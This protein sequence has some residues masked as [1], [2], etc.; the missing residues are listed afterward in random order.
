MDKWKQVQ[1]VHSAY[2]DTIKDFLFVN[3][4]SEDKLV[5]IL[6][7]TYSLGNARGL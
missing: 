3:V 2:S 4:D 1:I 6:L 7:T 5:V